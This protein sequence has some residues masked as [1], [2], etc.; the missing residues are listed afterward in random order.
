MYNVK[1]YLMVCMKSILNQTY[2]NIEILMIDDGSTDGTDMLSDEYE[3][4]DNRVKVYHKSNGGLSD[5]RNFGIKRAN[6]TYI[7]CIDSD[8]SVDLDYIE[9]LFMLLKKYN[10]RMSICQH[11]VVFGNGKIKDYGNHGDEKLSP[12]LCIERMLYHDI[13]DT[14]AWAKLYHKDLFQNVEYPKGKLFED[15]GTTYALFLQCDQIAIGYESKYNYMVRGNSIVT[16]AFSER[17]FDL[18]EMTDK[19]GR[20]VVEQ[21]PSFG[22][23]VMRRRVYARISTLNQMLDVHTHKKERNEIITFIKN[24]KKCVLHNKKTPKRDKLAILVLCISCRFYRFVWK[25]Y[26]KRERG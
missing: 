12:E 15:I 11:R 4:L 23:A 16:G 13:I 2:R 24:N 3:K 8:D 19:M 1:D 6:G 22:N 17:K 7:T 14:S 21:F 18:L 10:T 20:E 9:Y 25:K 26:Q 5:A